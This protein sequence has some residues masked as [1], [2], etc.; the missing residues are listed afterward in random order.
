MN[1][2]FLGIAVTAFFKL[3]SPKHS[4]EM[5]VYIVQIKRNKYATK[6]DLSFDFFSSYTIPNVAKLPPLSSV[7][8]L[9]TLSLHIFIR[10]K[11]TIS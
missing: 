7:R 8:S 11:T 6:T 2:Y 1:T 9:M 3:C 10:R 5:I 4:N